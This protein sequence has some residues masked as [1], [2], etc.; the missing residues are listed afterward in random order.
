MVDK[1]KIWLLLDWN[2]DDWMNFMFL[3]F[4]ES[5]D[6]NLKYWDFKLYFWSKVI[7]ENCKYYGDIYIDLV[8]LKWRFV[9]NGLIFFGLNVVLREMF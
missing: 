9:W 3:V 5:W 6:V 7:F 8:I 2:D 1:L 4:I